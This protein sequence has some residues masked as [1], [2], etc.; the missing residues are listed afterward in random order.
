M[1]IKA[2]TVENIRSF[3]RLALDFTSAADV[4]R[5]VL[6]LG[7]NGVGK[8]TLL[9]CIALGL[10]GDTSAAAL[11]SELAVGDLTRHETKKDPVIKLILVDPLTH[12]EYRLNTTISK[13]PSGPEVS[14]QSPKGFP[15][16]SIFCCGYGIARRPFTY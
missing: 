15:W 5:C 7:N 10:S 9:R 1:Y 3:D 11:L 16:D 12:K 6:I 2:V 14:V 8:T 4:R 13:G